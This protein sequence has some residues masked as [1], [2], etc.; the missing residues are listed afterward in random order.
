MSQV[1]PH[2]PGEP[3][4][5]HGHQHCW[6]GHLFPISLGAAHRTSPQSQRSRYHQNLYA[7]LRT[8]SRCLGGRRE[9]GSP[10]ALILQMEGKGRSG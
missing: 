2:S 3:Q 5:A 10:L 9:R 6:Q 1:A 8:L 4:W 7:R